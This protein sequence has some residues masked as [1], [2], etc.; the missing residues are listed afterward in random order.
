MNFDRPER[1]INFT[2][3]NACIRKPRTI[4]FI[5]PREVGC[6]WLYEMYKQ[7]REAIERVTRIP[8]IKEP[9]LNEL[10][11]HRLNGD[12]NPEGLLSVGKYFLFAERDG[13]RIRVEQ[14]SIFD[15]KPASEIAREADARKDTEVDSTRYGL[16]G[17]ES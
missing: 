3:T 9:V 15:G 7:R 12:Y 8:N 17:G 14:A 11:R 4:S 13:K 10:A 6:R 5:T 2:P 16:T 1:S